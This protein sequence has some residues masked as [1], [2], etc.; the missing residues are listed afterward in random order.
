MNPIQRHVLLYFL[1]WLWLTAACKVN[2]PSGTW[3]LY[4]IL[5]LSR[6]W[7]ILWKDDHQLCL[8]RNRINIHRVVQVVPVFIFF[9]IYTR[10]EL[11]C[12]GERSWVET[13]RVKNYDL[14]RTVTASIKLNVL[15][16]PPQASPSQCSQGNN[17]RPIR[18]RK[19]DLAPAGLDAFTS[20]R[21]DCRLISSAAGAIT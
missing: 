7:G 10:A 17:R 12:D 6:M 9:F 18:N 19:I 2:C 20:S 11:Y 5:R 14:F 13:L 21:N 3:K 16:P 8:H 15:A 4:S 1:Y